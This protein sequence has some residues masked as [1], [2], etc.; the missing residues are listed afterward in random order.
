[1]TINSLNKKFRYISIA[2]FLFF[3]APIETFAVQNIQ[4]PAATAPAWLQKIAGALTEPLAWIKWIAVLGG[5]LLLA[6][7]GLRY[8]AANGDDQKIEKAMK[9]MK[10]VL[11]GS[12]IIFSAAQLGQWW[13]GKIT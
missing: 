7:N 12:F 11:I 9:G 8:K 6:I 3:A 10:S 5:V 2:V 13:F 4:N 1:M